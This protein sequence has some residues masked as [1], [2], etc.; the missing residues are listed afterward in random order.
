MELP[1]N[2]FLTGM[3]LLF[4][5]KCS[6]D[7]YKPLFNFQTSERV[8]FNHFG[9]HSHCFHR[10]AELQKALY[11][12][13]SGCWN[14]LLRSGGL[15][16]TRCEVRALGLL[17]HVWHPGQVGR[18]GTFSLEGVLRKLFCVFLGSSEEREAMNHAHSFLS[19]ENF[20]KFAPV[21]FAHLSIREDTVQL[22]KPIIITLV[23]ERKISVSQHITVRASMDLQTYTGRDVAHLGTLDTKIYAEKKGRFQNQGQ[24]SL[25]PQERPGSPTLDSPLFH[26]LTLCMNNHRHLLN[27][28]W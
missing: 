25:G 16:T 21:D 5:N 19:F 4:F 9:Q 13:F 20:H 28:F 1:Q 3:K 18:V 8:D 11:C 24:R 15:N 23:I 7:C 22:G 17:G 2:F 27:P 26:V 14:A 12:H 6:S 10:G